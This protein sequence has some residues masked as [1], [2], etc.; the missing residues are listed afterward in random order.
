MKVLTNRKVNISFLKVLMDSNE[1]WQLKY[2]Q[3]M[4]EISCYERVNTFL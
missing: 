4:E 3:T 2:A 1:S